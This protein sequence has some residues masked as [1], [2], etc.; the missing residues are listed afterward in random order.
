MITSD[1]K[2][3][4]FYILQADKRLQMSLELSGD[5]Y[6][7]LREATRNDAFYIAKNHSSF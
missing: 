4:E 7:P 1:V 5:E 3:A 6:T 2:R